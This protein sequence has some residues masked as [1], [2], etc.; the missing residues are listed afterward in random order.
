MVTV[1]KV[2]KVAVGVGNTPPADNSTLTQN[3][4]PA[5]HCR[6]P[7]TEGTEFSLVFNNGTGLCK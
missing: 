2:P 3:V 1:S 5:F 6:P 7:S 4:D